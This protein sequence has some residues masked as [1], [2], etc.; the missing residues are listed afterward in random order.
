M[1]T[2]ESD[3]TVATTTTLR[4]GINSTDISHDGVIDNPDVPIET[5]EESTGHSDLE[6]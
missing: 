4:I 3:R 1:R 2:G 6:F 5:S